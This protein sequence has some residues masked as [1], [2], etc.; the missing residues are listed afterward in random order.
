MS[1]E[2]REERKIEGER[3]ILKKREAKREA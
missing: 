3:E 2:R 1:D